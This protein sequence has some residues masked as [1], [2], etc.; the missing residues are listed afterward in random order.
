MQAE[1]VNPHILASNHIEPGISNRL[2]Y[3]LS[4]TV[5]HTDIY[6]NEQTDMTELKAV[7]VDILKPKSLSFSTQGL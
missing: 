5:R 3:V 1:C 2:V 7:T 6:K 4:D